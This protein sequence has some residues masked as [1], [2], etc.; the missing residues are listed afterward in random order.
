MNPATILEIVGLEK[1]YG[2]T[3][4]LRDVNLRVRQGELVSVIGPSGSGKSTMLRCCNLLEVPSK[5]Q[6]VI[7]GVDL[8]HSN[9]NVNHVRQRIGMVFQQFNLYPHLNVLG[10]VT[11]ALR[12]V[13][14]KSKAEAEAEVLGIQALESVGLSHKAKSYPGELSGGQQQRVAIARAVA[15]KPQVMLFDEP[16]SALDPEL[17]GSVLSAMRALRENGMTML[18]V[19]HE[20][21]FAR[22][23]SD[24]VVFMDSGYVVEEGP[25]EQVFGSP[26]NAR[27][28]QFV[29]RFVEGG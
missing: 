17:V 22:A 6:I 26:Q 5:G 15:L 4:V 29:S 12:K 23:A 20:M 2:S 27:T 7:D 8:M 19:T 14:G 3:P 11:L 16:T 28:R 18:V 21:A 13:Q 1:S 10:N 9:T 24:K 25:P